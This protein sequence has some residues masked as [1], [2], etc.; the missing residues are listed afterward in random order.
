MKI[1]TV[2]ERRLNDNE[3][4]PH[5][6]TLDLALQRGLRGGGPAASTLLAGPARLLVEWL[7]YVIECF[8]H[9]VK[10]PHIG[11]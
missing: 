1:C 10:C 5:E 6:C 3:V 4:A 9:R 7:D 8:V 11:A 2:R